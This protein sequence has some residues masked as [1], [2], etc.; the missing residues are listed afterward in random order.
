MIEKMEVNQG[1]YNHKTRIKINE[2]IEELNIISE[3]MKEGIAEHL[4]HHNDEIESLQKQALADYINKIKD[5]PIDVDFKIKCKN[6]PCYCKKEHESKET[7]VCRPGTFE[8]AL[9]QLKAGKSVKRKSQ[10]KWMFIYMDCN[11]ELNQFN[12]KGVTSHERIDWK[13]IL[14]NDW[15]IVE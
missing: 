11:N 5:T 3:E 1:N 14:E 15:E 10:E 2:I 8:W 9:I 6:N 12:G 13:M 4:N 7:W